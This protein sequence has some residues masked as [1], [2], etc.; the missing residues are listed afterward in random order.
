MACSE[1]ANSRWKDDLNLLAKYIFDNSG[2][3]LDRSKGYLLEDCM[4]PIMSEFG[5]NSCEEIYQKAISGEHF[6]LKTKIIDAIATTETFFFRDQNP[7]QLLKNKIIP[8]IVDIRRQE[9]TSRRIPLRIWS[10]A[11]STGQEV[12]SIGI[13]LADI[14]TDRSVWDISILGSDI[15]ESAIAKASY[16]KY[17]KI[18]LDRG[19]S[20]SMLKRYFKKSG[21]G[22]RIVDEIRSMARFAKMD[23]TKPFE[24]L[25]CFDII[26]CRNVAIYFPQHLKVELFSRI[27]QKLSPG[28]ALI[29][30]GSESLNGVSTEFEAKHYLNALFYQLKNDPT[31]NSSK[32]KPA[33]AS[34]SPADATSANGDL[35]ASMPVNEM[36]SEAEERS[37]KDSLLASVQRKSQGRSGS[38]LDRVKRKAEKIV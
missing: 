38:L 11:C 27:A 18:E 12:Y 28:G 4:E 14:L 5:F 21:D 26:F 1:R 33:G 36:S 7:F 17:T 19:I 23:L 20:Q 31:R 34:S 24:N 37:L 10:A 8:D 32:T 30:G 25:K 13:V 6:S 22:W 29:I 3:Q 15:S 2:I 9:S 16:G 35:E